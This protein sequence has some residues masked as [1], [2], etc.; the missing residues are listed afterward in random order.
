MHDYQIIV[1]REET[2]VTDEFLQDAIARICAYTMKIAIY[3]N[4]GIV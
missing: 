2:M 4:N 1:R 3:H